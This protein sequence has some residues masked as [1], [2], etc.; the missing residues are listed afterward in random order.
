MLTEV[1][2]HHLL[3]MPGWHVAQL[4]SGVSARDALECASV[5]RYALRQAGED[6]PDVQGRPDSTRQ[7]C[8]L[9]LPRMGPCSQTWTFPVNEISATGLCH[10]SILMMMM[11]LRSQSYDSFSQKTYTTCS[12][13]GLKVKKRNRGVCF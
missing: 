10:S 8:S 12:K 11:F 1:Q 5:P 13:R 7:F 3:L 4:D 9:H 2:H 6:H